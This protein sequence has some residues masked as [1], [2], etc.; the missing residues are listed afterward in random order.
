MI[1]TIQGLPAGTVGF[2]LHGQVRGDDYDQVLVPAMESAI[3]EHDRIK[4]LLCFDADFEG[5][6][7]AAAWDDTLLGL[8]HW[9]GF[10]RIAV[11]SDVGWLRT[12]IR[13]IGALMPCPVRLF[14]SAEEEEARRWLGESLGSLH[15]EAEGDVL[16]VRLIGQL[17]PSAYEAREA[18]IAS[19][20][21]RPT[22]LKL[23]VDL[24]EFDGWSGLAAL[25]DHLSLVRE[26]RRSLS[27]VAVVGNQAWQH[28]AERLIRRLLPA[29][30]RFFDAAHHEQA[31]L[32][33]HAA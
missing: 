13:A 17:E 5:Y 27:R 26:H 11:V 18:E 23:L 9:Q 4:A 31:E 32:W 12:A 33:I 1:E 20:F 29:E 30:C 2:R 22:P 8:R 14:A 6:D 24:R 7:L 21:S 19:L 28:L 25:G 3:A 15:L 16:R 10:E